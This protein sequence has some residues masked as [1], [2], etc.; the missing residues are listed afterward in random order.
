MLIF[1][2]LREKVFSLISI[3]IYKFINEIEIKAEND[4]I[5]IKIAAKFKFKYQINKEK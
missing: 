3:I 4:R 2:I 5:I 1:T